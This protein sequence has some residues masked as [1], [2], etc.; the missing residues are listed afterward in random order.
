MSTS[1]HESLADSDLKQPYA[2]LSSSAF[3]A[4]ISPG[5]IRFFGIQMIPGQRA[6][7][8]NEASPDDGRGAVL[9]G[10][11]AFQAK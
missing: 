6:C 11:R 8:V 3:T 4:Y 1:R 7:S 9:M 10:G 5:D 2:I